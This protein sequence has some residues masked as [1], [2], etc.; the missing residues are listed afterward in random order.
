MNAVFSL[1]AP[2]APFVNHLAVSLRLGELYCR[3]VFPVG[4]ASIQEIVATMRNDPDF[5]NPLVSHGTLTVMRKKKSIVLASYSLD[6]IEDEINPA[7]LIGKVIARF[8]NHTSRK[9]VI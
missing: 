4:D 9:I 1:A 8:T 7:Q 6:Y 2:A 3:N 5:V